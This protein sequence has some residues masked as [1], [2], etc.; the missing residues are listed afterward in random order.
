VDANGKS[1][2]FL[3]LGESFAGYTLKAYEAKS[4]TLDLERDGKISRVTLAAETIANAPATSAPATLSDAE[5]VLNKMHFE[6]MMERALERQKKAIASSMEQQMARLGTMPGVDKEAFGVFQKK[7]MAEIFA[8][9]EPKQMKADVTKIYSEVFTKS[10]LD[11]MSAFYSTPFGETLAKKQPEV[12]DRLGAVVQGR[13]MEVM[14]RV[15]QM[16]RDFAMEQ[17]AKAEAAAGASATPP[18][19]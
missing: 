16:S 19:K 1:S 17:R 6:E 15:Q 3:T 10:E 9:M 4:S 5:A 2:S 18:A 13:M 14:P 12:Q 11:Q 8:V 7:M